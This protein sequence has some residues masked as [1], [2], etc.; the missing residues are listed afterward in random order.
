LTD[1]QTIKM[2]IAHETAIFRNTYSSSYLDACI[3]R[4]LG[5]KHT[6]CKNI[7]YTKNCFSVYFPENVTCLG[8][9]TK[10]LSSRFRLLQNCLFLGYNKSLFHERYS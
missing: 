4:H 2:H 10:D 8:W 5:C 6:F 9:S 7:V 3:T 1:S